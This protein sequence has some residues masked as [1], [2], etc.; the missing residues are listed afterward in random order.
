VLEVNYGISCLD[1]IWQAEQEV[2]TTNV[3]VTS[4]KEQ[5]QK[6]VT[7]A[8]ELKTKLTSLGKPNFTPIAHRRI[9]EIQQFIGSYIPQVNKCNTGGDDIAPENENRNPW[10]IS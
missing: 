2:H 8:H 6:A 3:R 5:V 4:M 10:G 1:D 9:W 7:E